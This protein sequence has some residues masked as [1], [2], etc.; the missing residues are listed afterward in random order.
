MSE[1]LK[2][3]INE[4]FHICNQKSE[5]EKK[6][7][8]PYLETINSFLEEYFKDF[9][10]EN[11]TINLFKY[12]EDER[13]S[14]IEYNIENFS[15]HPEL[16]LF[17]GINYCKDKLRNFLDVYHIGFIKKFKFNKFGWFEVEIASL[18]TKHSSFHNKDFSKQIKFDLQMETLKNEG[19][20]TNYEKGKTKDINIIATEST[21]QNL[22]RLFSNLGA[23][24]IKFVLQEEDDVLTL[25]RM[26]FRI[27]PEDLSSK[28]YSMPEVILSSD[29]NIIN[30]DER[31]FIFHEFQELWDSFS[32]FQ[33][34]EPCKNSCYGIIMSA[35]AHICKTCKFECSIFEKEENKHKAIREKNLLIKNKKQELGEKISS[36][37]MKQTINKLYN[38][39]NKFGYENFH[40]YCKEIYS[41][42]W[43]LEVIF[44]FTSECYEMDITPIE[45]ETLKQIFECSNGSLEDESLKILATNNNF[46]LIEKIIK[47]NIPNATISNFDI[48]NH[49]SIGVNY[50][51]AFTIEIDNLNGLF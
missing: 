39:M 49:W 29:E 2:D 28:D 25:D 45:E 9:V 30:P 38:K 8:H 19:I 34:Y 16:G 11:N 43:Q 50:I 37:I 33:T 44:D 17:E 24:L 13:L 47:E 14:Q 12:D 23:K 15:K 27:K 46:A 51:N 1:I 40:F 42:E 3:N 21:L 10:Y 48:Q 18:I 36:D 7:L 32:T 22:K 5:L 20:E 6:E 26:F 35:F 41:S 4:I 31:N